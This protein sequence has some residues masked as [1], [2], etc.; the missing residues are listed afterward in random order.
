MKEIRQKGAARE[1]E[2]EKVREREVTRTEA[3]KL[4][5]MGS[6]PSGICSSWKSVSVTNARAGVSAS[7]LATDEYTSSVEAVT[8]NGITTKMTIAARPM[9]E[10]IGCKCSYCIKILYHDSRV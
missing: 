5:D 1:R 4:S 10:Y 3:R 7:A 9:C 6:R 8:R 2:R